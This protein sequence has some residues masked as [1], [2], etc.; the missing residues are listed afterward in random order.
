MY[1][2]QNGWRRDCE[3]QLSHSAQE[4]AGGSTIVSTSGIRL[5]CWYWASIH[6]R[7]CV[8]RTLAY[9]V[10]RRVSVPKSHS[11]AGYW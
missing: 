4:T 9:A 11:M 10:I 8:E 7:Y 6:M 1:G 2:V 5:R 3:G